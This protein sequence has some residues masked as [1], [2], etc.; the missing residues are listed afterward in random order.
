MSSTSFSPGNLEAGRRYYWRVA[1][2]GTCGR[3]LGPLLSFT[4]E[5][6]LPPDQPQP[7]FPQ[8]GAKRVPLVTEL[9]WQSIAA[10]E[11]GSE[12]KSQSAADSYDVYYGDTNPPPPAAREVHDTALYV[13]P[14]KPNAKYFWYVVAKNSKGT[15]SSPVVQFTTD[16]GAPAVTLYY[17]RVTSTD[18][19]RGNQGYSGLALLNMD[20]TTAHL[21]LTAYD[22]DGEVIS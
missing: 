13:G 8:D 11:Q 4:T 10:P 2:K 19:D 6:A 7:S 22:K 9:R 17:P 15:T 3:S 16:Q 21:T 18:G 14:L 20:Q 12:R 5:P 1:A